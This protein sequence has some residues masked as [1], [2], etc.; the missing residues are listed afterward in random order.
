MGEDLEPQGPARITV[1]PNPASS[2]VNVLRSW[3]EVTEIKLLDLSGREVALGNLAGEEI[4]L[5]LAGI[6]NGTYILVATVGGTIFREKLVIYN[7]Y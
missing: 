7:Q 1:A 6:P 2:Y 5:S 3:S 4:E